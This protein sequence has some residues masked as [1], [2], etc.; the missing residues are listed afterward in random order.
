MVSAVGAANGLQEQLL[1]AHK[2]RTG[3]IASLSEFQQRAD[4]YRHEDSSAVDDY[5]VDVD[6]RS[7]DSDLLDAFRKYAAQR[8]ISSGSLFGGERARAK[9]KQK[10]YRRQLKAVSF[11]V[12]LG[13]IG[14]PLNYGI[15]R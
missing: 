9:N 6:A 4:S 10:Y 13:V 15:R 14:G 7:E 12:L 5:L 1:P 8:S 2:R 3:R 11:L